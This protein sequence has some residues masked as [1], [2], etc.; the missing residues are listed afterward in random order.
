MK[1]A[2]ALHGCSPEPLSNYL[3]ALGILRLVVEKL[4]PKAKGY[5][6]NDTFMLATAKSEQELVD[7][8]LNDYQPTPLVAPWNGSTGFYPKDNKKTLTA[9]LYSQADR[10]KDYREAIATAQA[11]VDD[12]GLT[13]QP[14]KEEKQKLLIRLRNTLPDAA[15]KWLDTCALITS[16]ELKFP[17]LTGTGGND[18]NFEFSRTFMQQLQE[19]FD[20]DTGKPQAVAHQFLQAA[21]LGATVPELQFAGKIGQFNPIAAGGA[22]AAPGYDADSRVNPWDY[23]LMLEGIMLFTSGATRRYEN[24]ESQGGF[25]YP[26]TVRPSSIGYGSA[27]EADKARAELWIP[28]WESPVGLAELQSLFLEGRA[29]VTVNQGTSI[30]SRPAHNGVDFARAISRLGKERGL[31]G[32]VR[33]SF[34]E[35]NGLSYFAIPLGRFQPKENPQA[36]RLAEIDSWLVKFSR[37]AQ[38][39][40]APASVKLAHR[41]L[42][43]AIIQF[44]RGQS[45]LL[46]VL[47]ALGEVEK[48]LDRSLRFTLDKRLEPIP[49]LNSAWIQDCYDQS[50]EFRLALALARKGL[51]QKVLP[52]SKGGHK[53]LELVDYPHTGRGWR[54]R[55]VRVRGDYKPYWF[56]QQ[57]NITTWRSG[58]FVQNLIH[59]LRRE[60]IESERSE[61]ASSEPDLKELESMPNR[62]TAQ[63]DDIAAWIAKETNDDRIEAIARGLSLIP[64]HKPLSNE[65]EQPNLLPP[66]AYAISAIVHR[67]FLQF[68]NAEGNLVELTLPRIP[69]FLTRLA[70]GQALIATKLAAQR[71]RASGLRPALLDGL[72]EPSPERTLRIAAALAF[73]ISNPDAAYLLKRIQKIDDSKLKEPE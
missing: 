20:L 67:R 68:A 27:S 61:K 44:V 28:L 8:F 49:H 43:E 12:L 4:D 70:S 17:P 1:E 65:G 25:A 39:A 26:F 64:Y 50:A 66:Y 16:D 18:G 7:F 62:P 19:L 56:D 52:I 33:Y 51:L 9:I 46:D 13:T 32:F 71:L 14:A 31:G 69:A 55:L 53:T 42:D 24:D 6:C 5:W 57:D 37:V 47:I 34:Q 48:A 11:Q 22:N 59:V 15:V 45:Q 10:F 40:A 73:P 23:I 72:D 36:D 2:I 41:Q 29:K 60:E 30:T 63:L 35:R 38:D 21:I 54:Q 3:K 58:S